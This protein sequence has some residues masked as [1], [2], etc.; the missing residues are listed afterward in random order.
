MSTLAESGTRIESWISE[1]LA[2]RRRNGQPDPSPMRRS[3]RQ[4]EREA[5]DR[6]YGERSGRVEIKPLESDRR[7]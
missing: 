4:V 5:M 2:G 3:A 1:L 6:L 7:H